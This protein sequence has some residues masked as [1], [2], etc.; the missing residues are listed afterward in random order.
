M[1][2][3]KIKVHQIQGYSYPAPFYESAVQMTE[4][5]LSIDKSSAR[6][7]YDRACYK[8][9]LGKDKQE[10][11]GDLKEA[12]DRNDMLRRMAEFDPDFES[13]Q[14]DK[15]FKNLLR[16]GAARES[17]E[18]TAVGKVREKLK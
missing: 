1:R 9:R 4:K 11:L 16:A 12:I 5:A 6:A 13:L 18:E 15:H 3:V 14:S 7:Y 2:E 17:K 10:V 8:S